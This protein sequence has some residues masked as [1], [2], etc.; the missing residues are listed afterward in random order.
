MQEILTNTIFQLD[1]GLSDPD[2]Y[3]VLHVDVEL[4]RLAVIDIFAEHTQPEHWFLSKFIIDLDDGNFRFLEIDPFPLTTK[5]PT[6][7]ALARRDKAYELI[8]PIV[9]PENGNSLTWLNPSERSLL[10]EK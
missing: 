1:V 10:V 3:R 9:E 4:D 5:K 2:V 6:K 8:R 7:S